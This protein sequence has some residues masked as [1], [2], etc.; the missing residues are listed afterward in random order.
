VGGEIAVAA[1]S[2][3]FGAA[4]RGPSAP[5][6][7]TEDRR[8]KWEREAAPEAGTPSGS[9]QRHITYMGFEFLVCCPSGGGNGD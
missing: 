1:I 6:T 7:R 8:Q 3:G 9:K 4:T 2:A 5:P